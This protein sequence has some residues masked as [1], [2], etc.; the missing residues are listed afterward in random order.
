RRESAA[1]LLTRRPS[2]RRAH[3]RQPAPLSVR[4]QRTLVARARPRRRRRDRLPHL[5]L[6]AALPVPPSL[7]PARR[8][9][10]SGASRRACVD[11]SP[12]APRLISAAA[13]SQWLGAFVAE[14][15]LCLPAG[16]C[17]PVAR[18]SWP[19][20]FGALLVER[21]CLGVFDLHGCEQVGVEA[22][23]LQDRGRDL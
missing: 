13:R 16:N 4:R 8:R 12:F 23:E 21:E 7:Y 5:Q 18:R 3:L 11:A 17:K 1:G 15:S 6:D 14:S 10:R 20:V 9:A 19:I 2:R 22:E